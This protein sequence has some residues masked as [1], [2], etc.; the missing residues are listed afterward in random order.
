MNKFNHT[1]VVLNLVGQLRSFL[2]GE[3]KL[4]IDVAHDIN[5]NMQFF[6]MVLAVPC[7]LFPPPT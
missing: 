5:I 2:S 4:F 7:Q 3:Q 6:N 1:N